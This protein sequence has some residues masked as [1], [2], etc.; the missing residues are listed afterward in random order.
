MEKTRT[1]LAGLAMLLLCA[2][3]VA[4]PARK[5][6]R[7]RIPARTPTPAFDVS[8][9]NDAKTSPSLRRGS[10]GSAVVRAQVL[11]DRARFSPGEIDGVF[12]TNMVRAVAGFQ[13]AHGQIGSGMIDEATWKALNADRAP[14]L[15]RFAIRPEDVVGPFYDVPEDMME[16][17]QLPALGYSSPLELISEKFHVSPKLLAKLNRGKSFDKA[18]EEILVPNVHT[19][20]LGEKAAKVVVD[21]TTSTVTA[22]DGEGKMIAQYPATMGSEYDPLPLGDW[23]VNGVS[24]NPP[25]HYNPDLFWD[26]DAM[27]EKTTIPPGPNN[28]V[29]VVWIDLSKSHYGIHGTPEPSTIGKTQ[30]HG[31]IRLTNWDAAELAMMLTPGTRAHLQE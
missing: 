19:A 12:G 5:K 2:T 30:S 4:E 14:V 10:S 28:P 27:D 8:A 9:A 31:C 25:F 6:S 20:P 7:R 15:E 16:K 22:F 21:K 29:G 1:V 26:A 3:L 23:K 11:L 18:G 13:K 24:R 17:A